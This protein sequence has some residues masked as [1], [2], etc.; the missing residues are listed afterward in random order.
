MTI[1]IP[2]TIRVLFLVQVPNLVLNPVQFP[3]PILVLVTVLVLV[4]NPILFLV[5]IPF[6]GSVLYPFV[7][8]TKKSY[9]K[10]LQQNIFKK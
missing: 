5:L 7:L 6:P 1:P 8:S 4:P 9:G 2:V 3:V 10:I